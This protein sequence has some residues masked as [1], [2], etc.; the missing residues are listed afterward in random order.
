[1]E[2]RELSGRALRTSCV[3]AVLPLGASAESAEVDLHGLHRE[4]VESFTAWDG[5]RDGF[6]ASIEAMELTPERFAEADRDRDGKLT[7]VEWVDARFA[8]LPEPGAAPADAP[9]GAAAPEEAAGPTA[10]P[11]AAAPG[12]AR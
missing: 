12:A 9:A 3:L 10:P 4:A 5:D 2:D 7:L 1:V 11:E 8:E 6:V